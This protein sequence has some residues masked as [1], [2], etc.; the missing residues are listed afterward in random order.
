M[1]PLASDPRLILDRLAPHGVRFGLERPRRLLEALGRPEAAF[2]SVLV[3][4]TNGKGSTATLLAAMVR[5]AGYRTGLYTSPA[6]ESVEG[7]IRIGG[8]SI[9]RRRLGEILKRVIGAAEEVLDGEPTPFEALTAAAF[10]HFAAAEVDLAVLEAGMGGARDATNTAE[11]K[12]S[13][14]TSLSLEHRRWLGDDL[15]A[16]AREKAGVFRA[17]RPALLFLPTDEEEAASLDLLEAEAVRRRAILHRLDREV[18]IL[19]GADGERQRRRKVGV[20]TPAGRYQLELTLPGAHQIRNLALAVRAAEVLGEEGFPRLGEEAIARG[21]HRCRIPGRLEWI[22]LGG[23]RWALL[24]IAHNPQAVRSLLSFLDELEEPWD[25]LFGVLGD[26]EVE[27]MLPPL[28]ERALQVFLTRAPGPR[29]RPPAELEELIPQR[30]KERPTETPEEALAQVSRASSAPVLVVCGS[31]GLV[32]E[33]RRLLR[34]AG[35]TGE[36]D[37]RGP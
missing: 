28:A 24:D 18:S 5:A 9:D 1:P 29:A 14:I 12:L 10:L 8:R 2:P 33:V 25:L 3:A 26:K 19:G 31:V 16:I 20:H 32:G 7:Q 11:P 21:T 15:V 13:L 36:S 34:R 23:G 37:H 6:V 30:G 22:D 27:A 35:R 4:G 17:D